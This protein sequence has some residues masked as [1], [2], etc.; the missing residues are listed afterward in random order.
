MKKTQDIKTKIAHYGEEM[1]ICELQH[2]DG[3]GTFS[4]KDG[5]GPI[6]LSKVFVCSEMGKG[7]PIPTSPSPS[8]QG[9]AGLRRFPGSTAEQRQ[10]CLA[11][12][13]SAF[14]YVLSR[15]TRQPACV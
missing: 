15:R 5:L 11:F 6:R 10:N 3:V 8:K 13:S 12:P 9:N 1:I 7:D 4:F 14:Y 2:Y